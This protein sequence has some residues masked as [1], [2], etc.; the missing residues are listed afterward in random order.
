MLPCHFARIMNWSWKHNMP[1]RISL[2]CHVLFLLPEN[3]PAFPPVLFCERHFGRPRQVNHLRSRVRD[4]P[5]QQS[6]TRFL[7]KIQILPRILDFQIKNVQPGRAL[8]LTPIIPTLW[9]AKAGGTRDQE[10]KTSLAKMLLGRLRKENHLNP[11]GGDCKQER[12]LKGDYILYLHY[13]ILKRLI[14]SKN[15]EAQKNMYHYIKQKVLKCVWAG[16]TTQEAEARESLEHGIR[17]CSEPRLHYCTPAWATQQYSASKR[18]KVSSS[19]SPASASQVTGT[20][21]THHHAWLIFAFLAET[22][23][24]HVGQAGLELQTSGDPPA[25]ASQNAGITG[26]SHHT[27]PTI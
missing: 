6:K 1:Y 23:F 21:G 25:L 20:T 18:I 4:Q 14:L 3:Y 16:C 26:V 27:Q 19:D 11:G 8:W 22:G 5:P 12:G 9:E 17:G 10:F 15:T 24:H 7:L 2:P 13:W